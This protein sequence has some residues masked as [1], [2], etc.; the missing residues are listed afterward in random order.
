[1]WT[2]KVRHRK[3]NDFCEIILFQES[4]KWLPWKR[5][6]QMWTEK[7]TPRKVNDFCEILLFLELS[8]WLPS[9]KKGKTQYFFENQYHKR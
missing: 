8:K 1:M 5:S 6:S 7:V 3:V 9:T 2:E 4:S